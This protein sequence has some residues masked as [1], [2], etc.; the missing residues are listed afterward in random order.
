MLELSLEG[1]GTARVEQS[2]DE[3]VV[4]LAS[5]PSPPGSTL[6][7]RAGDDG[8]YLVKVRSCRRVDD[9][10]PAR[11]RIEGRWVNLSRAQRAR[12]LQA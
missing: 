6:T 10:E 11:F 5:R 1:G 8:G 7:G 9:A 3:H 2:D 12:V 4:L